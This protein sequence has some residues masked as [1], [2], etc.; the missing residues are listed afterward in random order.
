MLLVDRVAA[1]E[2]IVRRLYQRLNFGTSTCM[3]AAETEHPFGG[4]RWFWT[5]DNA[6]VVE[7]LTRPEIASRYA[8][9]A[10]EIY[11]FLRKMC[12]GPF[13]FR[14]VG[15]P[16]LLRMAQTGSEASFYH[17]MMHLRCDLPRGVVVAGIRFHDDRT[18]DNLLLSANCVEF[19]HRGQQFS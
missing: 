11:S 18:A 8:D 14:R 7:F 17:T 16:R 6:K 4:D 9:E 5:D 19:T 3:A 1:A 13:I 10:A 12:Y 2:F 15:M